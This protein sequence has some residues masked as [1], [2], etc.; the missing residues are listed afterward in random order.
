[1][2]VLLSFVVSEHWPI[3]VVG[4]ALPCLPMLESS[5]SINHRFILTFNLL[6][7]RRPLRQLNIFFL[8]NIVRV[9]VT[10]LQAVNTADTHQTRYASLSEPMCGRALANWASPSYTTLDSTIYIFLLHQF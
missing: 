2:P 7:L 8:I 1:M 5:H 6:L 10:K 4:A 3:G 9:L